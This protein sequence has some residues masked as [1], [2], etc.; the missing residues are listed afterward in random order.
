[1][2]PSGVKTSDP[3]QINEEFKGFFYDF[4]Q[5]NSPSDENIKLTFPMGF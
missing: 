5:F 3:K 2:S 4:T 1:M